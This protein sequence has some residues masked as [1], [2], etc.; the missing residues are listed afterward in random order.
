M[1]GKSLGKRTLELKSELAKLRKEHNDLLQRSMTLEAELDSAKKLLWAVLRERG[2]TAVPDRIMA[3]SD[4]KNMRI[5]AHYDP[6]NRTTV[7]EAGVGL[8]VLPNE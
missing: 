5:K 8:I 7:L 6:R 2:R 1:T 3:L 4:N